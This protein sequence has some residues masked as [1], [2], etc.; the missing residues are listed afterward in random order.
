MK[1]QDILKKVFEKVSEKGYEI[2]LPNDPQGNRI[3]MQL[4]IKWK[5][6][7]KFIFDHEFAKAFW[8][9]AFLDRKTGEPVKLKFDAKKNKNK[10]LIIF[11]EDYIVKWQYELQKMVLDPNPIQ[12]LGTFL[13]YEKN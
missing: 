13:E 6:Y 3:P 10:P 2:D 8:G 1:D 12:Y 4:V 11:S 9:D 7:T 5:I